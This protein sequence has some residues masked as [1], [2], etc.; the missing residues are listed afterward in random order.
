MQD[1]LAAAFRRGLADVVPPA[2]T[3]MFAPGELQTLISGAGGGIDVDDLAQHATFSGG[4]HQDH[5]IIGYLWQVGCK[6][7]LGGP[8]P[9]THPTAPRC[10][11]QLQLLRRWQGPLKSVAEA[12][13]ALQEA[14]A[15]RVCGVNVS[16]REE[17]CSVSL[18]NVR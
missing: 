14:S 6:C 9:C 16:V 15:H 17:P 8:Q 4:Y 2:W 18:C 10:L 12:Q 7:G 11:E 5:P 3:A 1:S 13:H